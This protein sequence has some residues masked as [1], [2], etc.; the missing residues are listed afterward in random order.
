MESVLSPSVF[1]G[2]SI[3]FGTDGWRGMIAA[4]FTFERVDLVAALSAK[5]LEECYGSNGSRTVIVG[6]D[7]R[8]LSPE[9]ASHAAES[10]AQAGYDVLLSEC[11][12]PTPAFSW[13]AHAKGAL[14]AIVI[15]ASHNPAAYSGLK[16]K[17]AFGGSV[18]PEVTQKV[19]ALLSDGKPVA[20]TPGTIT[21]FNPWPSYCEALQ[22][23]VDIEAIRG[24][25]ADGQ[26]TV[27]ADVMHGSAASGFEQILGMPIHEINGDADPL[28]E[29]GAPEPLPKYIPK[30]YKAIKERYQ[31]GAEGLTVGIIFDGDS[32]RVAG[33]DGQGEFLSSQVLIPILIDHLKAHRGFE[34]EVIKTISG[35]NLMQKVAEMHGLSVH[36]TP[37]GYKYIADRMLETQVLIGGEESGG[38]GY[39]HHIPERD[40]LLS[41]L[42]LLE[43]VVK[44]GKDF[45]QLNQALRQQTSFSAAYDRIDLPLANMEVRA[46][47]L[48]S[49]QNATPTEVAGKAVDNVL[50]IDGYKF[51]LA[52]GSWLLIRFS[53]T[54]PVLRLY[55]EAATIEDVHQ[56]LN[57][58]KDW[59]N[60]I[61]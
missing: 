6:Y 55:S 38:I 53:G 59:A 57:W 45:G 39:G 54:E 17:G 37:I 42:Y 56:H 13:A 26:L 27:F 24:A 51:N 44:S 46:K 12:A 3:Q 49:L 4:D 20:E 1:V 47:L 28:F 14:G 23:M 9:F 7:R 22:G 19:E 25:I 18:P 30:L 61:G 41:A 5:V 16:V 36:E 60:S 31:S 48:D 34:G 11:F 58:A 15:T 8:F 21:S 33:M 50:S 43:A 2:K 29:G 52:D 32:D 35:S 10:V 40:A